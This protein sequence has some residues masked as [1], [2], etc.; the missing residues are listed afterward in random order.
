M[1]DPPRT[2]GELA[3]RDLGLT[4]HC[5]NCHHSRQMLRDSLIARHGRATS[6][7][8]VAR[9]ARCTYCDH[10]G[11]RAYVIGHRWPQAA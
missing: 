6:I 3:D 4:F 7:A 1:S 8:M 5:P 11:A 2:L 10:K 9:T